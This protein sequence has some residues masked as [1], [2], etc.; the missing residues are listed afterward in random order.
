MYLHCLCI[1]MHTTWIHL[2]SL[3][4]VISCVD[5]LQPNNFLSCV[6][7]K[8]C[9]DLFALSSDVATVG[10]QSCHK[11]ALCSAGLDIFGWYSAIL[12]WKSSLGSGALPLRIVFLLSCSIC[13]SRA[14]DTARQNYPT[15]DHTAHLERLPY[16]TYIFT[17][18]IYISSWCYGH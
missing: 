17:F 11:T 12:M 6:I 10:N 9:L 8:S 7:W 18:M 1:T 2:P 3:C 15:A 16:R 14:M 4:F 13:S 5:L